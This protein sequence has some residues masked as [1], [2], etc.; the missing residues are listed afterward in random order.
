MQTKEVNSSKNN[1]NQ[2][3]GYFTNVNIKN[4]RYRNYNVSTVLDIGTNW[5]LGNISKSKIQI[6]KWE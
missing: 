6:N 3:K 4:L 1:G 5:F 2:I